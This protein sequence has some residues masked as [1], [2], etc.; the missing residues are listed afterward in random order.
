MCGQPSYP[1]QE[2]AEAVYAAWKADRDDDDGL[3][4]DCSSISDD[5]YDLRVAGWQWGEA[6]LGSITEASGLPAAVLVS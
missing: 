1:L 2:Y 4:P 6:D 3:L 5:D